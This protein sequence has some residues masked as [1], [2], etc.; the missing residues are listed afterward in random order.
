MSSNIQKN[1]RPKVFVL[2]QNLKK[3]VVQYFGLIKIIDYRSDLGNKAIKHRSY[4]LLCCAALIVWFSK[5]KLHTCSTQ[6]AHADPR[7]VLQTDY[8]YIA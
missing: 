6:T 7:N 1:I 8:S 3:V 4:F 2:T 5:C